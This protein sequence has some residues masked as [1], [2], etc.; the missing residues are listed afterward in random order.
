MESI[1]FRSK[2]DG[3]LAAVMLVSAAASVMAVLIVAF[4][5]SP[6]LSLA[7]SPLLA[8]SVGLPLWLLRATYYRVDTADLHIRCGP[9]AWRV[10]LREIRAITPTRN[11]LSSPALSLDRLRIDFAR[12]GSIMISPLDKDAFV[13]ELRKRGVAI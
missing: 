6:L 7:I 8:L 10:P 3:W 1:T 4:V 11:P 9:F 12:G 13:E 2:V 5:E